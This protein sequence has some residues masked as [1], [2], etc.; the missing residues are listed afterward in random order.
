MHP[1]L[2]YTIARQRIAD[3]QRITT[4]ARPLSEVR[5]VQPHPSQPQ[6]ERLRE[7]GAYG[8]ARRRANA[9]LPQAAGGAGWRWPRS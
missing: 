4:R 6:T 7:M 1:Y 3:L 2:H 9:L 5:A 8:L